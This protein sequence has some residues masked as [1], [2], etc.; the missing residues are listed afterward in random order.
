[1]KSRHLTTKLRVSAGLIGVLTLVSSIGSVA[2]VSAQSKSLHW[3]SWTVD[4]S[5]IDTTHNTFHVVET[6]TISID[7]GVFHGA[8]R[9]IPLGRTTGI[10]NVVVYDND[11]ALKMRNGDA[12]TCG[13]MLGVACVSV[14]SNNEEAIYWNFTSPAQA[15]DNNRVMKIA[16]DVYGALRS[17]SGGDQLFWKAFSDNRPFPLYAGQVNV[18]LPS[19]MQ[20]QNVATYPATWK[21]DQSQPGQVIFTG[22]GN[23]GNADNVEVRLQYPHNPAMAAPP[24]QAADD[25]EAALEPIISLLILILS[26]LIVVGGVLFVIFKFSSHQRGLGPVVVPEYLTEPPSDDP[27]AIAATLVEER[28][29]SKFV[30][31]TLVDLARRGLLV[32]EQASQ[33]ASFIFHRTD[34]SEQDAKLLPYESRV[35]QGL[36]P[37]GITTRPMSTLTNTFYTTVEVVESQL[38]TALVTEGY[39]KHSPSAVRA[40]WVIAGGGLAVLGGGGF[41]LENK[42]TLSPMFSLVPLLLI[43][44]IIV[45]VLFV[46]VANWM[47]SRTPKGHQ[48][49]AKWRAFRTYL[50]NIKKYTDLQQATDQFDRYIGY[51]TAFGLDNQWLRE[52]SPALQQMPT[53]YYPTYIYG[54]YSGRYPSH[55]YPGSGMGSMMSSGGPGL[56]PNISG[57]GDGLGGLNQASANLTQGLN[58]MS[59][60]MTSLLNSAAA[61][62]TSKPQSSGSSSHGGFSGGGGGGHS[63]GGGSSGFH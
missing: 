5:A 52:F 17:Y 38:N 40:G 36:F 11:T 15:A 55:S 18:T 46:L 58:A 16:Y 43:A 61:T 57:Q 37:G 63:S 50:Q 22:P 35:L 21:I 6:Q 31:A 12:N 23:L 24:W 39:N 3:E 30:V 54:P 2:R 9:N 29:E 10:S 60:G 42:S 1:M 44:L 48:E 32:I 7:Y 20:L 45:G 56:R 13:N 34:L 25:R 33:G 4:I 8:S 28:A 59:S 41:W 26:G 53:W 51:A 14:N 49:A 19:G 47:P 62:M 27:P